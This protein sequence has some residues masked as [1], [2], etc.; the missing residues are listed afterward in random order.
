MQAAPRPGTSLS[1]P[2]TQAGTSAAMRPLTQSVRPT[3]G[4]ARPGT[5]SRPL[6]GAARLG[7]GQRMGTAQQRVA[8]ALRGSKP[9]T[10]RPTTTS[11]RFVRLGTASLASQ[12]G[13]PF[14]NV[15]KLSMEKYA[16]RKHLA[17][18]L[19]DYILYN[20][21]NAKAASALCQAA[22]VRASCC[23]SPHAPQMPHATLHV[24]NNTSGMSCPFLQ[25]F[26]TIAWRVYNENAEPQSRD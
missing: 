2:L 21:H 5:S 17:R 4:F 13:G 6:T 18:V 8:T 16:Q 22:L 9:G 7:T 10:S 3:T 19:C 26:G 14:I 11:G 15:E 12:P 25:L 23:H 1:R 20:D 24:G